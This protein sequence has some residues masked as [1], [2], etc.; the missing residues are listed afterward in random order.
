MIRK[1]FQKQKRLIAENIMKLKKIAIVLLF[2]LLLSVKEVK[3]MNTRDKK[4]SLEKTLLDMKER[5]D[6]S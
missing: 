4:N 5:L 6:I 2:M 1:K 3:S